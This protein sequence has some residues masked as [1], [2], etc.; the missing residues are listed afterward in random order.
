L[1]ELVQDRYLRSIPVDPITGRSDTWTF[2]APAGQTG[3]I[4]DL[5][6]GASG[7]AQD[8]SLYASW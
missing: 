7:Q 5:H 6:S 4:F 8:G 2:D 1:D 3:A